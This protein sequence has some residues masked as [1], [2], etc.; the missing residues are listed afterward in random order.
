MVPMAEAAGIYDALWHPIES[1]FTTADEMLVV[2]E[3]ALRDLTE[4][5]DYY[6]QFNPSNGWGHYETF[7]KFIEGIIIACIK[8]PNAKPRAYI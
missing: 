8:Y 6:E 7:L 3:P 1:G 5:Q 2:L 4:R